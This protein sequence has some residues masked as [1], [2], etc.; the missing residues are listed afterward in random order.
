MCGDGL[1][2]RVDA[3]FAAED[4]GVS[5]LDADDLGV[6]TG[7]CVDSINSAL[8]LLKHA[9]AAETATVV[10]TLI[11]AGG[12]QASSAIAAWC[13]LN[14]NFMPHAGRGEEGSYLYAHGFLFFF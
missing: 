12:S 11:Q 14:P 9:D 6:G 7:F 1:L 2:A 10:R 8:S 3:P 4:C 5:W 13:E